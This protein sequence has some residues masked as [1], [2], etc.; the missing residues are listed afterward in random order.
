MNLNLDSIMVQSQ[1]AIALI[2]IAFAVLYFV[3]SRK[4]HR[5]KRP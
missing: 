2:I 5:S 4:G 3:S 1:I